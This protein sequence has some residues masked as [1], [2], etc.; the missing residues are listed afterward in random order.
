M[1]GHSEV[2]VGAKGIDSTPERLRKKLE[3]LI[4]LGHPN[5]LLRIEERLD[6]LIQDPSGRLKPPPKRFRGT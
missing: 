6:H 3:F 1:N 4:E 5:A 2:T